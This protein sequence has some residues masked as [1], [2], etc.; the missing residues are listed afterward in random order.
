MDK[1]P[2]NRKLSLKHFEMQISLERSGLSGKEKKHP[3][4]GTN[5]QNGVQLA[6]KSWLFYPDSDP[7]SLQETYTHATR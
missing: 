5:P 7:E 4:S 6:I 2:L 1:A 3:P